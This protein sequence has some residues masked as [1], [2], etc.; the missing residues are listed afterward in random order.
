[1][2]LGIGFM[3]NK[4]DLQNPMSRLRVTNASRHWVHGELRDLLPTHT[5][6]LCVTN[7]SRHWVHGKRF[8]PSR[9]ALVENLSQM[10]LGI[11]FMG[12]DEAREENAKLYKSQMP[13]GIGFM[14]NR[15]CSTADASRDQARHK[16]LSALGSWGT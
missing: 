3:G 14:G 10:P 8:A 11:G 15:V 7:A 13:L 16:C 4:G 5:G 6:R 9:S 1:M 12:N 2:P